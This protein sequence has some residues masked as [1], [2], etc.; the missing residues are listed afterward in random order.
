[1]ARRA[2]IER[3]EAVYGTILV[4]AIIVGLSED[5]DAEV[6]AILGG[7]LAT[8]LVFWAAH[9]YAGTLA[10][11]LEEPDRRTREFVPRVMAQQ[12]PLVEAAL[13]PALAL[14]LGVVGLLSRDA[15]VDVAIAVGLIALFGWGYA[16]GRA[17]GRSRGR[18]ALAGLLSV[19]LGAVMVILKLLVH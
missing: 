7:V 3:A 12:W 15:A 4:L 9:V 6:G 17:V 1:M 18:A 16:I 19:A 13:P 8:S 10:A 2:G 5:E 11:Q 14:A